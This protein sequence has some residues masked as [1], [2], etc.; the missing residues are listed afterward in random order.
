MESLFFQRAY[1]EA[2]TTTEKF[3]LKSTDKSVKLF[4]FKDSNNKFNEL[5]FY[6]QNNSSVLIIDM[7][8]TDIHKQMNNYVFKGYVDGIYLDNSCVNS[9]DPSTIHLQNANAH[10][11]TIIKCTLKKQ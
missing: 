2:K 5:N 9:S 4:S 3:S 8:L 11:W 10:F 1:F 7:V 6:F